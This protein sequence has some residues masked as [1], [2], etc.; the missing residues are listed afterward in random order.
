MLTEEEKKQRRRES[1]KRYRETHKDKIKAYS[2]AYN[3]K[4]Y[5]EHKEENREKHNAES[6]ERYN[7][8]KEEINENKRLLYQS[9]EGYR[10]KVK[11][12]NKD[13]RDNNKD[14]IKEYKE[15][16]KEETSE[17][18]KVYSQTPRGRANNLLSSYRH[19]DRIHN[20]G[21]CTLTV[22]WILENIF[23]KPCVYCG[24]TDWHEL[25]CDRI[26]NSKPHTKDNV[27][28]CCKSCNSKKG[29]MSYF[30]YMK[31]LGN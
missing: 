8:N 20:R 13:W 27:V 4:H 11:E 25:G 18:N 16:H 10:V 22:D 31:K 17:Y 3:K 24:E 21:E 5:A 28:T 6:I 1:Q 12:R 14:K 15:E 23:T 7:N 29:E 26:D 2:K 19:N 9:D 30:E